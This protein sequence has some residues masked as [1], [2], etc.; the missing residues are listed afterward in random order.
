[1]QTAFFKRKSNLPCTGKPKQ[2]L[3]SIYLS[4]RKKHP[5]GRVCWSARF[6]PYF[7]V[8]GQTQNVLLR[9][10]VR[11]RR[12]IAEKRFVEL[13]FD[14]KRQLNHRHRPW[15]IANLTA[16][17]LWVKFC[18]RFVLGAWSCGNKRFNFSKNNRNNQYSKQTRSQQ[19]TNCASAVRRVVF[20]PESQATLFWRVKMQM[21]GRPNLMHNNS[22][23]AV[24]WIG[25][26]SCCVRVGCY[27]T[28]GDLRI[29]SHWN[30]VG[31]RCIYYNLVIHVDYFVTLW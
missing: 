6:F 18:N 5:R 26:R 15:L 17:T 2:E 1:M 29:V 30:V 20:L 12:G 27:I 23:P 8:I 9:S 16:K 13:V 24:N 19:T 21:S 28:F 22:Q 11:T 14:R 4:S 25:K 3:H 10:R 7:M 31:D